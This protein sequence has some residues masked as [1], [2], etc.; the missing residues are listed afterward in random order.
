M[1][2]LGFRTVKYIGTTDVSGDLSESF[3]VGGIV[4]AIFVDKTNST[5]A[6]TGDLDITETRT[7]IALLDI[8]DITANKYVTTKVKQTDKAGSDLTD[9]TANIY[10]HVPVENVTIVMAQGGNTKSVIIYFYVS[11]A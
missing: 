5:F 6:D 3:N 1:P 10:D 8:D 7:G 2:V 9:A 4:K 11:D